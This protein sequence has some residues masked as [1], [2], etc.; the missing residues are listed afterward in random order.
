MGEFALRHPRFP[1]FG[2]HYSGK[3]PGSF[4]VNYV[5]KMLAK[6]A[7]MMIASSGAG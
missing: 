5:F 1:E 6:Q 3:Y 4:P 7:A 2:A